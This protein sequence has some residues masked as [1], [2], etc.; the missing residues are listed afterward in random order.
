MGDRRSKEDDVSKISTSI[1]VT[2]FPDQTNAKEL[3]RLCNQYGNVIDI[4]IPNRRSKVGKSFG[5]VYFIKIS[6]V[7]RLVNNLCTIWIGRFHLHANIARFNRPPMCKGS[8]QSNINA[9]VKSVPVKPLKNVGVPGTSNSYIQA[10]KTGTYSHTLGYLVHQTRIFRLLKLLKLDDSC[11]YE[12]DFSLSLV[13]KLKEFG[14]LPNLKKLLMEEG[15]ND[16]NIRYMRGF[17]VLF[18]FV[19]NAAKDNFMSHVGVNSWFSNLQQAS[20]SFNIDERIAWIDIESVLLI[21]WAPNFNDDTT[22]SDDE[23]VDKTEFEEREQGKS[24]SSALY[25]DHKEVLEEGEPQYLHGFTLCDKPKV[26]SNLEQNELGAADQEKESSIKGN[27]SKASYKEDENVSVCSGHFKSVGTPK[28]CGSMLQ[29]IEDLIK[30]GQ[31]MGYKMEG[32]INDIEE[33]ETEMEQV[34]IFSIKSCWGNLTFDH[35]VS[36]SV[37]NSGDI[38]CVWDS[39][40]F[41]KEAATVS[42]YLITIM[43]KWL[44]SDKNLLIISVYAPKNIAE[45]KMLWQY[46][47]IVLDRWKGDVVEN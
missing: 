36:P 24:K 31:T 39:N 46:L 47:K 42:D 29:V 3:W 26:N 27:D 35:V 23:S 28:I 22:D 44:P 19:N 5:F 8:H 18:K 10:V 25:E 13:G 15:F 14:F 20:N 16:I 32:C 41:Y 17:W 43:G 33:I 9:N 12:S 34:D 38:L 11:L 30:V 4:F 2:N 6:D 45:K 37:G 21:G 40:M 1:F 7:E